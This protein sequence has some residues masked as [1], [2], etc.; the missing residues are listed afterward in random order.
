MADDSHFFLWKALVK[1]RSFQCKNNTKIIEN[2]GAR[3]KAI[4]HMYIFTAVAQRTKVGLRFRH[5]V[6]SCPPVLSLHLPVIS[7]EVF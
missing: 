3:N 4:V 5:Q 1:Y 2:L 6:S 7:T